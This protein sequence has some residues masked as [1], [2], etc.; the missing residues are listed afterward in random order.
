[1]RYVP[2]SQQ[3]RSTLLQKRRSSLWWMSRLMMILLLVFGTLL[4]IRFVLRTHDDD[5]MTVLEKEQPRFSSELWNNRETPALTTVEVIMYHEAR[6]DRSGAVIHDMLL[7]HAFAF[8]H[9]Y[10]YGGACTMETTTMHDNNSNN[11]IIS[12]HRSMIQVLGLSHVLS[13]ACP[14]DRQQ[15]QMNP[16]QNRYNSSSGGGGGNSRSNTNATIVVKTARDVLYIRSMMKQ[17]SAFSNNNNNMITI[18]VDRYLYTRS[19]TKLWT[20]EWLAYMRS[21]Q[22]PPPPQRNP[23]PIATPSASSIVI[24][25]R[26]GDVSLCDPQTHDRYLPNAYYLYLMD[27]YVNASSSLSNMTPVVTIVSERTSTPEGWNDFENQQQTRNI[28][29]QLDGSPVEAWRTMMRAQTLILST[30][31]FSI[32]PALFARGH[33]SHHNNHNMY[34]TTIIY[35]PCW[36]DPLPQWIRVD[37]ETI[38]TMRRMSMRLQNQLCPNRTM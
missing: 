36:I 35:T 26:R 31:S 22:Q 23:D 34:S 37:D 25:I 13:F 7:A 11:I 12:T 32:V 5:E 16:I 33:H 3:R 30:S 10:T 24:H 1:M 21:Q 8:V 17:H 27:H 28:R 19:N 38:R 15:H 20:P 9:N 18:W 29:F 14:I 2:P 4:R 6:R